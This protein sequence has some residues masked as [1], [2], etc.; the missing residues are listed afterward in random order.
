M[1]DKYLVKVGS[2]LVENLELLSKHRKKERIIL[3]SSNPFRIVTAI[4][5]GFQ[6]IPIIPFETLHRNDF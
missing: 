4:T 3:L 5:S 1:F 6:V 2:Y